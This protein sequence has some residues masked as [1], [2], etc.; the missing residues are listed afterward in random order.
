MKQTLK[1]CPFCGAE[2]NQK[3]KEN[4][5]LE[6]V[7]Q[8]K[9]KGI[10]QQTI[11]V[12]VKI[13]QSMSEKNP[14]WFKEALDRQTETIKKSVEKE[15]RAEG[16][17]VLTS[18]LE[19][20]G[21]PTAM[22]KIQEENITK[23]LSSLKTGQ[24]IFR[25][26]KARKSQE[27]I[28]CIIVENGLEVGKILIESKRTRNWREAHLDQLKQYMD[29]ENTE[30]GILATTSMPDDSLNYAIW[31]SGVLI[32]KTEYVEAAYIFLREHLKLKTAL[33]QDYSTKIQNLEVRDQILEELKKSITDGELD[34]II[35]RINKTTLNIDTT[36]LR[37]EN[38]LE[39]MFRS[40]KKDSSNIRKCAERLVSEHIERIRVQL[41]H[42]PPSPF[43]G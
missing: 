43:S 31:R 35:E 29:R 12:A 8:L 39:K 34:S 5:L 33:E 19:L 7:N 27:D 24:D 41:I 28:E 1:K 23:R 15:L 40:I 36:I 42:Q 13:V 26:E 14:V 20:K 10:L 11:F 4:E 9:Q 25:T 16:R 3:E 37:A 2:L 18:I 17:E 6:E 21:N 32:V 22:G 38:Y 30:F